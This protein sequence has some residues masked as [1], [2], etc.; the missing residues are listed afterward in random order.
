MCILARPEFDHGAVADSQPMTRMLLTLQ[1]GAEQ[2]NGA[3]AIDGR[4]AD[5]GIG[6]L[7]R[8][9][10]SGAVWQQ[11]GPSDADVQR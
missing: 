10:D 11:F 1:R 4:A 2:G 5:Q 8:V 7:S 3:A 6:E 9:A